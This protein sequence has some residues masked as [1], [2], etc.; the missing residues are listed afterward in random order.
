MRFA[1][2][3]R[4]LVASRI[5][6]ATGRDVIAFCGYHGWSDWYLSANLNADSAARRPPPPRPQ[7]EQGVRGL[8]G[9]ALPFAYNNEELQAI[10]AETGDRLA[11]VIME[12]TRNVDPVPGFLEG[13]RSL[14]DK[15]GRKLVIDEVTTGFRLHPGDA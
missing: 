1:W 8:R 7:P 11:A 6:R 10:A 14:C 2:R 13:V 15:S 12:P 9:T 3:R 5:V 4:D